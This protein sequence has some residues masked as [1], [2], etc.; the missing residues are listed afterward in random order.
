METI[1]GVKYYLKFSFIFQLYFNSAKYQIDRRNHFL[2][3]KYNLRLPV[4]CIIHMCMVPASSWRGSC[5]IRNSLQSTPIPQ[6]TNVYKI[7]FTKRIK[8]II[9][10]NY[11]I[12][13]I[14]PNSKGRV[15]FCT[16][17]SKEIFT[18]NTCERALRSS[19][20]WH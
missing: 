6:R 14:S 5:L 9:S 10:K 20:N 11:K 19:T 12:V 4:F 7:S 3:N 16:G 1:S 17:L 15:S 8:R 18:N 13:N 2:I